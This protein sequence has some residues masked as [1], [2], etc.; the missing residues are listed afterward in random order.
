MRTF[1]LP[2]NIRQATLLFPFLKGEWL[3]PIVFAQKKNSEIPS[4]FCLFCVLAFSYGYCVVSTPTIGVGQCSSF[5][6]KHSVV[7]NSVSEVKS[8]RTCWY[9]PY[10]SYVFVKVKGYA[11]NCCVKNVSAVQTNFG[12]NSKVSCAI[13]GVC[14][15]LNFYPVACCYVSVR[16]PNT[17][18]RCATC[19][20]RLLLQIP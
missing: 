8:T 16:V 12:V 5:W 2:F 10:E 17:A 3:F 11:F 13:S 14:L 19:Y 18:N 9:E 1:L 20:Q 4:S 7:R 15:V 6:G